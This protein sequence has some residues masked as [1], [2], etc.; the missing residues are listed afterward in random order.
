[1][2]EHQSDMASTKLGVHPIVTSLFITSPTVLANHKK[3]DEEL[4]TYRKPTFLEIS[5]HRLIMKECFSPHFIPLASPTNLILK[6]T[7]HE[8]ILFTVTNNVT[9]LH[10]QNVTALNDI[11]SPYSHINRPQLIS[12]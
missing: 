9:M 8:C 2:K 4:P 10:S 12:T 6:K 11:F 5:P 1:M 7:V 3:G